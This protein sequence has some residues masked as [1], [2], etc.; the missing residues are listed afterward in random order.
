MWFG[1]Y[2][3]INVTIG[4]LD[5]TFNS[6]IPQTDLLTLLIMPSH[7]LLDSFELIS[8]TELKLTGRFFSSNLAV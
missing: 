4:S 5:N 7:P 8:E 6:P 3:N 1:S 2:G